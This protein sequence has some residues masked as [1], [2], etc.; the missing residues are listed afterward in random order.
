MPAPHIQFPSGG[1]VPHVAGNAG[2][3]P[4]PAQAAPAPFTPALLWLRYSRQAELRPLTSSFRAVVG[5]LRPRDSHTCSQILQIVCEVTGASRRDIVAHRR[6]RDV[7][8]AR[9]LY[10]W[11]C[12]RFTTA[13]FPQIARLIDR[14]HT[15][16]LSNVRALDPKMARLDLVGEATPE[17]FARAF[18]KGRPR[19]DRYPDI[20]PA[21]ML[22]YRARGESYRT[23][24]KRFG[25]K[26][27]YAKILIEQR[28]AEA[29]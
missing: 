2:A 23:I 24:G 29:A 20:D 10:C 22:E 6:N 19:C 14:D 17:A 3:V 5:S 16:I 26:D 9:Q 7:T 11:L 27:S 1:S 13:S 12:H 4:T 21:R 15:T 25:I 8:R 18:W 28:L